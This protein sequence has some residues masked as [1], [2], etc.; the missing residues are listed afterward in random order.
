MGIDASPRG[1]MHRA[2]ILPMTKALHQQQPT[3]LTPEMIAEIRGA[4][5]EIDQ[6][7]MAII[8]RLSP[9]E[10]MRRGFAMSNAVRRVA[11]YRLRQQRPELSEAEANRIVLA[12]YYEME[13]RFNARH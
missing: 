12:R 3:A 4:W 6:E 8:S 9:A 1:L 10:R 7:Q 11:V 2:I 13:E 5:A